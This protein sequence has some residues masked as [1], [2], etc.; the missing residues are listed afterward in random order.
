MWIRLVVV[1]CTAAFHSSVHVISSTLAVDRPRQS[2]SPVVKYVH[3]VLEEE[4]EE[5][6]EEVYCSMPSLCGT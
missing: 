5:E 3:D 2:L 4:E 6:E 1:A